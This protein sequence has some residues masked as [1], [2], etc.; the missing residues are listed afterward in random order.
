ML[1]IFLQGNPSN[2]RGGFQTAPVV[3]I[4]QKV[5]LFRHRWPA[6]DRYGWQPEYGWERLG[7][8]PSHFALCFGLGA[9]SASFLELYLDGNSL[10]SFLLPPFAPRLH[11]CKKQPAK[12]KAGS[13]QWRARVGHDQAEM[14]LHDEPNAHP[15]SLIRSN[16]GRPDKAAFW[17]EVWAATMPAVRCGCKCRLSFTTQICLL[18]HGVVLENLPYP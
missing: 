14:H 7:M 2:I 13:R 12:I 8:V 16:T 10:Q 9:N 17:Y 4:F 11:G 6:C 18:H 1:W 5:N 15:R 3:I